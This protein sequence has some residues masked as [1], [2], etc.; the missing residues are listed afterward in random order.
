MK[1]PCKWMGSHTVSNAIDIFFMVWLYF[2]LNTNQMNTL[3]Y[4]MRSKHRQQRGTTRFW[5]ISVKLPSLLKGWESLNYIIPCCSLI[6]TKALNS[7]CAPKSQSAY[8]INRNRYIAR[9]F[10]GHK[11][12]EIYKANLWKCIWK[13]IHF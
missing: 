9:C 2:T 10:S 1:L 6:F 12:V 11:R 5:H 4:T 8:I 3:H 7:Q 13:H